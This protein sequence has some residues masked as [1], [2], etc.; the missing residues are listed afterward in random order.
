MFLAGRGFTPTHNSAI[1]ALI[2]IW[3]GAL[4]DHTA[5]LAPGERGRVLIMSESLDRGKQVFNYCQSILE[6]TPL[7]CLLDGKPNTERIPLWNNID[8]ELSPCRAVA[9]RSR[10]TVCA[11]LDEVAFFHTDEEYA[12][13]DEAIVSSI[14]PSMSTVKQPLLIAVS[15]PYARKGLL[16]KNYNE[17]HGREESDILV[18]Q[19]ASDLMHPHPGVIEE[20]QR[21]Y[22]KDPVSAAAEYGAQFRTDIEAYITLDLVLACTS[23]RDGQLEVPRDAEGKPQF[24]SRKYHAFVDPSG[25]GSD[26]FTLAIA[27]YEYDAGGKAGRGIIDYLG[28][29]QP[30]VGK[31]GESASLS[32]EQVIREASSVLRDYG[33][34]RVRGD[35]YAGMYPRDMFNAQG[36]SYLVSERDRSSIYVEFRPLM[37]SARV[38]LPTKYL[39]PHHGDL[40]AKLRMQF[41]QLERRTATRG[42]DI[43]DHPRGKHDDVSN[44]VAG[45]LLDAIPLRHLALK[46]TPVEEPWTPNMR[47]RELTTK[48]NY[49]RKPMPVTNPYAR[50][51]RAAPVGGFRARR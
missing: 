30:R 34:T 35:K 50:Q 28:A 27:H 36:I 51:T 7:R 41:I 26:L 4:R 37:L 40:A 17:H 16:W 32:T 1:S 6:L 49:V 12:N 43:V 8:I 45:A 39:T 31:K 21:E 25:G 2:A 23:N 46:E 3:E 47:I 42:K 5:H 20:M 9:G 14:R 10:T 33:I 11:I 22:E 38:D 29:W 44:V 13:P 19:A 24:P 48:A 15:S 18:W